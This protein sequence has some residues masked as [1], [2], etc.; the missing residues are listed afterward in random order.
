VCESLRYSVS[1]RSEGLGVGDGGRLRPAHPPLPVVVSSVAVEVPTFDGACFL[2]FN[3]DV[4]GGPVA[5]DGEGAVDHDFDVG[6]RLESPVFD[7]ARRD[8]S[9]VM[10]LRPDPAARMDEQK[11]GTM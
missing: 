11:V 8:S 10:L 6:H 9:E 4:D 3:G 1:S 5:Q 7:A 2:S